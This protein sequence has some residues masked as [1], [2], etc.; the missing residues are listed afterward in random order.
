MNLNPEN[1]FHPVE[2]AILRQFL[3]LKPRRSALPDLIETPTASSIGI[4]PE[5]TC[6]GLENAVARLCLNAIQDRLPQWFCTRGDGTRLVGRA[7]YARTMRA[8]EAMPVHL[9]TI[10][11]AGFRG[12]Q[13]A[14]CPGPCGRF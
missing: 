1:L 3:K 14:W 13:A 8:V 5:L 4:D 6:C 10:N 9:M 12:G 11:W 7:R 2:D